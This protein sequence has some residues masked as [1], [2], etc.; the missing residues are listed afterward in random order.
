V[1]YWL[2]EYEAKVK[3]WLNEYEQPSGTPSKL[4]EFVLGSCGNDAALWQDYKGFIKGN[5]KAIASVI[6]TADTALAAVSN[7]DIAHFLSNHEIDFAR[8][9]TRKSVLYVLVRQQDL[10]YYG[11]L[12]NL[13]YTDLFRHLL[14]ER[15]PE[16]LPVYLLLDE[17]GHLTIPDFAIFATTARKYRVSFWIFLQSLSQLESRYG[18]Q[19]TKTIL[20]G[21]GTEIYMSGLGIETA[22]MISK[23][24]GRRRR[25][26]KYEKSV[27]G[28]INLLNPD[29]I[30]SMDDDEV[31]L[32]HSNKRPIRY[33]VVPF[34]R[35]WWMRRASEK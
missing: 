11:F 15:N 32:L 9:R 21:I 33:R 25:R 16:H 4:D 23:R 28:E 14:S 17:F 22:E 35:Q 3:Y 31:L 12:L 29:E 19:E 2:N 8:L 20:D 34:Y 1:K 13:F 5:Q 10:S 24:T 26:D 7:P 27:Y 18:P 6:M 30:I